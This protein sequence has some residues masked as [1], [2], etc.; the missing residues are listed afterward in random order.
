V[1]NSIDVLGINCVYHE[2]SACLLKNGV[3]VA[4]VEEERFNR[5]KH[6]KPARVDNPDV[7]PEAA[8][9][10]CLA[11]AGLRSLAQVDYIGCSIQPEARLRKNTRYVHDY[12]IPDGSYGAPE[13]EQVLYN[14]TLNIERQLR[15]R[16][17][18]GRFFY[19]DHHDC[20]AASAFYPSGYESAAVA[21]VDGIS[22]FSSVTLYDGEGCDL[23]PLAALDYPNSLG[24]LWEKLSAF[25]GFDIYDA[26][27]AMGLSSYGNRGVY[28]AQM[29]RLIQVRD[30]GFFDI[31]DALL[32]LRDES[33]FTT[34]EQVF[35]VARRETPV[36]QVNPK[37]QC[38]ADIALAAQLV[39]EEIFLKLAQTLKT[40]TGRERLCMAGGVALNCVAN[41]Y[42]AT[43]GIFENVYVPPAA[44]DAG[45][46]IGAA[47]LIWRRELGRPSAGPM[48][49]PYLGPAYG[50]D[51]IR[52]ALENAGLR[53]SRASDAVADT[54]RHLAD[55][56]IVAWF[57][58]RM[59]IGPRALGARS[60]LADPRDA[61]IA[62]V[63]NVKVK[64]REVFRPF[65]PSVLAE[66]ATDW[67]EL[68]APM[69]EVADY[70]LGAFPAQEDKKERMPAVVHFDGSCRI[71]AVHAHSNPRFHALLVEFEKLTGVPVLLNTSF[72]DQEPIVCSPEDAINTF[73]NT[74]IDYLVMGDFIV[75]RAR[76]SAT[77]TEAAR[78][79][80]VPVR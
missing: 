72:N 55:G 22:E 77:H 27:K 8:I 23:T 49:S 21:V 58:G 44:N 43:S 54:A 45:T 64:H 20:H 52:A 59:E 60:L 35:G 40:R 9:A 6:A 69:P 41:G 4:A 24:F 75:D 19:L 70:M 63:M 50:D 76:M 38:Y 53:Y 47:H 34:L 56:A 68:P 67:F 18:S 39:T 11:Q 51:A 5:V 10:F 73:L 2:S 31:D 57:Q 25:I 32:H 16:G 66:R 28:D 37:T 15:A 17:F 80:A 7:L 78:T 13:G 29:A 30:D 74:R 33:D 62:K 46:A 14:K 12:D 71:Q 65:C 42:L 36:R 61:G 79:Q 1:E 3:M 26:A 48:K